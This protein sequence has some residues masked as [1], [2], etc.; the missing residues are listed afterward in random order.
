MKSERLLGYFD[1]S[2]FNYTASVFGVE[3]ASKAQTIVDRPLFGLMYDPILERPQCEKDIDIFFCGNIENRRKPF[4]DI[5]KQMQYNVVILSTLVDDE[6]Y[7]RYISRSKVCVIISRFDGHCDF[8]I[9]RASLMIANHVYI[10]HEPVNTCQMRSA[11]FSSICRIVSFIPMESMID[12]CDAILR[13]TAIE[14]E[15][16]VVDRK[17]VLKN[18]FSLRK[19]TQDLIIPVLCYKNI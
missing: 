8:D 1:Y 17:H 13:K 6:E 14:R 12:A 19:T 2:T 3:G 16:I 9:Y 10:I 5:L 15:T 11:E 7:M 4:F 18:K